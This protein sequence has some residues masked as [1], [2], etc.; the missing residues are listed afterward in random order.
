VRGDQFG[1]GVAPVEAV[2]IDVD[3]Q[4]AELLEVRLALGDLLVL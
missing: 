1:N 3:P 4:L 2:G